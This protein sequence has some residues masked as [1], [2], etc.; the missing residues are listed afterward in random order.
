[1]NTETNQDGLRPLDGIRVLE[2]ATAIQG[3]AAGQL[4]ADL[5]AEVIKVEP[6][7]GDSSRRIGTTDANPT[8]S[9]FIAVNRGKRSL[10]LNAHS[11]LGT[12]VLAKLAATCDVFLTNFREPALRRMALDC[13]SLRA[14]NPNLI[15]AAASGFGCLGPDA[16]KAMVDGAAMAR[17]GLT[18]VTGRPNERPTPPGATIADTSGAMTL[19]LGVAT[20]L[21][22]RAAKGTPRRVDSSALGAQLWL[23]IWE[24]QHTAL[25]GEVPV[26]AGSHHPQLLGPIGVYTTSDHVPYHFSLLLAADAWRALWR[27]C[28]R[29]DI[30]DDPRWDHPSKQFNVGPGAADVAEIRTLMLEAFA[31]RTAA[32]WDAFLATEPELICERVLNYAE[33][34]ADHQNRANGYVSSLSLD[35]D[36]TVKTVGLPVAFDSAPRTQ[37]SAPPDLGEGTYETMQA[38]GFSAEDYNELQREVDAARTEVL[39]QLN[40]PAGSQR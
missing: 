28:E 1:M 21:Y 9:Q 37:F 5:G 25:T 40:N 4:L 30:A 36:N 20:A 3:P 33:V 17:G 22:E 8:G 16:T 18:G 29:P 35:D 26:R 15:Y 10:C 2:F 13:E 12:A 32:Q 7:L 14:H 23:Q 31:S 11:P 6:P 27:F 34:L 24:L 19:A 38:L 39:A